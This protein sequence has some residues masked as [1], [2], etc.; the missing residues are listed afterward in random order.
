MAAVDA[1]KDNCQSR[2]FCGSIAIRHQATAVCYAVLFI[3]EANL[4]HTKLTWRTCSMNPPY[5]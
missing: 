5:C 2:F 4:K 1:N 3:H